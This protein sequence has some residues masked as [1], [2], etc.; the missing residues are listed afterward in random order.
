MATSIAKLAIVLTTDTSG[1]QKG[2]AQGERAATTFGSRI[3]A[4]GAG[5]GSVL[6]PAALAGISAGFLKMSQAA[7]SLLRESAGVAAQWERLDASLKVMLGSTEAARTLRMELS[8]ID[9]GLLDDADLAKAAR[10]M[11]AMGNSA[12]LTADRIKRFADIA[13]ASG[14]SVESLADSWLRFQAD[15]KV[16]SSDLTR[17]MRAGV[18]VLEDL[19]THFGASRVAILEMADA[20]KITFTEMEASLKRLTDEGGKF[21]GAMESASRTISGELAASWDDL[22]ERMATGFQVI[23]DGLSQSFTGLDAATAMGILRRRFLAVNTLEN[24]TARDAKLKE[25]ERQQQIRAEGELHSNMIDQWLKHEQ[26][27]MSKVK[28]ETETVV[29]Q[30]KAQSFAGLNPGVDFYSSAGAAATNAAKGE[31]QRMVAE[32]KNAVA[33]LRSINAKLAG[34]ATF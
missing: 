1:M 4:I 24:T 5:F 32:Q 9:M 19:Q 31:M 27:A 26:E 29:R 17:L 30:I 7:S 2:F 12:T 25:A 22:L 6:G 3:K 16:T 10:S 28:K 21:A 14:E 33:E 20:G 8:G 23:S 18:P 11:V 15:G 34:V 13:I